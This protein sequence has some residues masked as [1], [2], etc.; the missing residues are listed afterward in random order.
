MKER[1]KVDLRAIL[2]KGP[3]TANRV[4]NLDQIR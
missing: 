1:R 3:I 4:G 2:D